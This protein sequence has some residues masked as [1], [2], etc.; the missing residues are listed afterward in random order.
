MNRIRTAIYTAISI[1]A[2]ES[3]ILP[4]LILLVAWFVDSPDFRQ[5]F[6]FTL[7]IQNEISVMAVW[8]ILATMLLIGP[9]CFFI[10]ILI[11]GEKDV[12]LSA[13]HFGFRNHIGKVYFVYPYNLTRRVASHVFKTRTLRT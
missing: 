12:D 5:V 3:N 9:L 13:N 1:L 4:P 8:I 2:L 11:F 6:A 7:G 10:S